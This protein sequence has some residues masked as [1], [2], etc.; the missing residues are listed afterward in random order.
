MTDTLNHN[1]LMGLYINQCFGTHHGELTK[2]EQK[3]FA[4]TIEQFDLIHDLVCEIAAKIEKEN[5]DKNKRREARQAKNPQRIL[6]EI[7]N[8][9]YD[10]YVRDLKLGEATKFKDFARR[11]HRKYPEHDFNDNTLKNWYYNFFKKGKKL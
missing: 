5:E 10:A 8:A 2:R 3:L 7:A 6:R 1:G 4:K 9:E 11:L